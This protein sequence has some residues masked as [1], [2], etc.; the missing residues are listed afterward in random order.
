MNI[1]YIGIYEP[2]YIVQVYKGDGLPKILV[3]DSANITHFVLERILA[4]EGFEVHYV[5]YPRDLVTRLRQIQP[6]LLFLEP[7]ISGGK[8]K[9]IV[10]YLAQ[11]V[12]ISVPIILITRISDVAKYQM[13]SWPGVHRLIRK[14]LNSEKVM[15]AVRDL[16]GQE[17]QITSLKRAESV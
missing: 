15:E 7:E 16:V 14:P 9:R 6:D 4:K 5:K 12:D 11:Q 8:G 10:T 17:Q 3:A 1:L 13:E 2:Q